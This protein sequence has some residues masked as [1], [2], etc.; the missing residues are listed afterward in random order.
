MSWQG[1]VGDGPRA[2]V[3]H[4]PADD[5]RAQGAVARRSR[6]RRTAASRRRAQE[7]QL[8]AAASLAQQRLLRSRLEVQGVTI[9]PDS[10]FTHVLAGS[11]QRSTRPRVSLLERDSAVQ[12]VYPV[13]VAY[14]A[15]IS[16]SALERRPLASAVGNADLALSGY[17]G[18][19]D[20]DRTARHRRRP[21]RTR[22]SPAASLPASTSSIRAATR[23]RKRPPGRPLDV[24]R[25]GT[26][27]AGILVGD[28][29]PPAANGI[30]R[31]ATRPAD[32]RRRL[33]AGR[34]RRLR[35]LLAHGP[36]DRRPRARG[37]PERRRRRA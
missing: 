27:M 34:Q 5:R 15:S 23:R 22:R 24:E 1:L 21:Q 29:G 35:P 33:A 4:R 17:D 28:R 7:Q 31:G 26:E 36:A 8:D 19:G 30:A 9:H 20:H 25:H 13:R 16:S 18:R 14:P 32:P 37:R 12:G 10:A 2:P 6:R 11:R 3:R